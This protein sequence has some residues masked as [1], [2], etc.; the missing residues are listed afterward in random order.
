MPAAHLH[1]EILAARG[2]V[3]LQV[4]RAEIEAFVVRRRRRNSAVIEERANITEDPWMVDGPATHHDPRTT[5]LFEGR[6]GVGSRADIAID[7]DR[8]LDP[9]ACPRGPAPVGSPGVPHRCG[10]TMHGECGYP[11]V[12]EPRRQID[13][14]HVR[15]RAPPDARLDCHW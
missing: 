2:D 7:H 3:G 10:T 4:R 5:R 15:L 1:A 9:T 6:L 8:D 12:G 11:D 14:G 13:D